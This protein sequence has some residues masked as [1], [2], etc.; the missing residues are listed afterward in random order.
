MSFKEEYRRYNEAIRPA[1]AL[2]EEMKDEVRQREE[3]RRS[4]R[5][6][7]VRDV[8]AAAAA[9]IC[10]FVG[11]PTLAA[12]IDPIYS[13]MYR[14]SPKLAQQFRL[15][16]T[17]DEDQGIR[18]EVA[19]VYIEGGEIQAYITLQD[20]EG[21][22]I[23]E[24]TDLNDS[25]SLLSSVDTYGGGGYAPVSYDA[26][27]GK[28]TFLVM[29]GQFEE[30]IKGEKVTF[31]L[32][33]LLGKKR[34]YKNLEIPIPWSEVQQD[35][36]TVER[37]ISGGSIPGGGSGDASPGMR[38]KAIYD[39]E[40]NLIAYTPAR[41]TDMLLPGEPDGRLPVEGI[42][43]T[44]MGYI[45]GMLRIQTAVYDS[46]NNDNHCELF[47][48]DEA[49]NRRIYDYKISGFGEA[50]EKG[51]PTRYQEC[52]FDVTPEE[53]EQYTLCGDFTVSGLHVTGH[54]SVTFPLE[55]TK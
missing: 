53:L 27:T 20:L 54:W 8:F 14:V 35:P 23:D 46:L 55:Q 39:G 50:D 47:L 48:V 30:D 36:Q 16:Q 45:G 5:L 29:Q 10:I 52:I 24:T 34:K 2:V 44:G 3:V 9:C 31:S 43:L 42:D 12:N 38:K 28:A 22:R 32:R 40:G 19:A 11:I 7:I 18:M 6:R 49:G 26:E 37:F 17:W 1:K 25:Y 33:E 13:I 21:D 4:V 51:I 15:V 41:Y